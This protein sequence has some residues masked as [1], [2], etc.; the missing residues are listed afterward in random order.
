M[1]LQFKMAPRQSVEVLFGAPKY[2]KAAVGLREKI[3][4]L[5]KLHSGVSSS[6]LAVSSMVTDHQYILNKV[7][8][9]KNAHRR[10]L[11]IGKS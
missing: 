5:E 7:S 11:C 3:H 6:L 2:R 10:R 8:L 9:S 4:V 1:I